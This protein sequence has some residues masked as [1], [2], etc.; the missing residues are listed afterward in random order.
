MAQLTVPRA[1]RVQVAMK[2]EATY[3]TDVFA[4]VYVAADVL[5]CFD[6]QP[7]ITAEEIENLATSGDLGRLPSGVGAIVGGVSFRMFLRGAGAAYSASVKPEADLALRACQLAATLVTTVGLESVSYQPTATSE[8]MT[9]YVVVDVPGGNAYS[10]QL[11]GCLGTFD[12]TMRA[13]GIVEARFTFQGMVDAVAD[14]TY[15]A[16]SVAATPAYPTLKSA[17]FQIGTANYAPRIASV[18]FAAGVSL[19][20]AP[21]INAAQGIAGF[22]AAD[23]NPRLTIDP[24]AD[25]DANFAWYAALRD[26]T[27]QD[28]TFQAG[29]TQYNRLKFNFNAAA[30]AGLQVIGHG[31]AVRDG[32]LA[33]NP[34][35]LATIA[36]GNDDYKLV[37]D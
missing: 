34:I 13:G 27:L 28:S 5:R 36:S 22:H 31:F 21:S 20:R 23:R 19:L 32:L 9:I 4:G 3:G 24:E 26:G 11:V 15:V 12:L 10:L 25:R 18:A 2:P 33:F 35:L 16:G 17:L 29:A 14:I 8:A 1:R 37:F 30:A 6:I 7:S